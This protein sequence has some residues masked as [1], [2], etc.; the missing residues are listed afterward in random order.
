MG[1]K[2]ARVSILFP[3]R[4]LGAYPELNLSGSSA[5]E[6]LCKVL[7]HSWEVGAVTSTW[8]HR[9]LEALLLNCC[10]EVK[11]SGLFPAPVA[12]GS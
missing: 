1:M 8:W 9:H 5:W 2:I 6:L 7:Q 3:S 10:H 11:R 4:K 12:I